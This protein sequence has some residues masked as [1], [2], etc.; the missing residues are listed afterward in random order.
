MGTGEKD[1]Q[2]RIHHGK[3]SKRRRGEEK[4]ESNK[5]GFQIFGIAGRDGAKEGQRELL[6]GG[7]PGGGER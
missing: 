7:R 4:T 6:Y 3:I 5:R 1:S 2:R